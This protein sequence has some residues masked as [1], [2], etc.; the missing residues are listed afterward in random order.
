MHICMGGEEQAA[1][2]AYC[3]GD[4]LG[5]VRQ[6]TDDAR[7]VVQARGY[8]HFG[9]PVSAAGTR[10]S[11]S[12]F[13]NEQT[14]ATGL[15]YLRAR[16]YDPTVGRFMSRDMWEGDPNQ[17]MSYSAWLYVSGNPRNLIDPSGMYWTDPQCEA[18]PNM[19]AREICRADRIRNW[20]Y[21]TK[22]PPY[23]HWSP[24]YLDVSRVAGIAPG[25]GAQFHVPGYPVREVP[26]VTEC[27]R[28]ET[29]QF[30]PC[31]R[32]TQYCGQISIAAM[33]GLNAQ[34]VVDVWH[35]Y[36]V[37]VE[38]EWDEWEGTTGHQLESFVNQYYGGRFRATS[39]T[40]YPNLSLRWVRDTLHRHIFIMPLVWIISGLSDNESGGRVGPGTTDHWVVITGVSTEAHLGEGDEGS[41]LN[42]LR[43]YNPFTNMREYYRW[44]VFRPAW[45]RRN[46]GPDFVLFEPAG[47]PGPR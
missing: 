46:R 11:N 35:K 14:D 13:T 20:T 44:S 34:T 40:E 43:I 22:G 9:D 8:E 3:L 15:V 6:L 39:F 38:P 25:I 12:L 4:E 26:G 42:W 21:R 24:A 47:F 32:N 1:G 30:E 10:T 18:I 31:R 36:A 7:A 2:W 37:E 27:D 29:Q 19:E 45:E 5:S 28:L 17:P 33:L 16:F 23:I 41:Y